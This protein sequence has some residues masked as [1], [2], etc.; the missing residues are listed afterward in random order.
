MEGTH[1]RDWRTSVVFLQ[2][3]WKLQGCRRAGPGKQPGFKRGVEGD[4]H[5]EDS[6]I[7]T[8]KLLDK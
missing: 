3:T 5:I 2:Q 4:T 7:L 1:R 8:F 6:R